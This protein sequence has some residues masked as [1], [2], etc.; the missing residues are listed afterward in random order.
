MWSL[1]RS[2]ARFPR[3]VGS[4]VRRHPLA[5]ARE[6]SAPYDGIARWSGR[7]GS[8]GALGLRNVRRDRIYVAELGF[9]IT[10]SRGVANASCFMRSSLRA[11]GDFAS[12]FAALTVG[13]SQASTSCVYP[14]DTVAG[15]PADEGRVSLEIDGVGVDP[16]VS[17]LDCEPQGQAWFVDPA[18][19]STTLQLCPASCDMLLSMESP[20]LDATVSCGLVAE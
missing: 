2:T 12:M 19:D 16:V 8:P 18:T 14:L 11:A 9:S 6:S 10:S 13:A 20:R 4:D 7:Y 17:A 15:W 5:V 3:P 1:A